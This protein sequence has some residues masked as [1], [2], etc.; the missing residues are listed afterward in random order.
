M[1]QGNSLYSYLKKIK[2]AFLKMNLENRR[3]EKVQSGVGWGGGDWCQWEAEDVG[4]ECRRMNM[5]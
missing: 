3:T 5:V 4:K 1:S 2:M